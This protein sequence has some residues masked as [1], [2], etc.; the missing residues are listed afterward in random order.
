MHSWCSLFTGLYIFGQH[1]ATSEEPGAD[2]GF[3]SHRRYARKDAV[4]MKS[5]SRE[6]GEH[7]P[8]GW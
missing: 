4:T 1:A 7:L 5:A 3:A 8:P 6:E 2:E